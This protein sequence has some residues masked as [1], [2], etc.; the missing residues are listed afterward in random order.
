M[1]QVDLNAIS[2]LQ[3]NKSGR[4][5]CS[6]P[7]TI[8]STKT[9]VAQPKSDQVEVSSLGRE[10][11][12]LV[13]KAKGLSDI[14]QERVEQLRQMVQSGQYFVSSQTIADAILRDENQ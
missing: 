9:T 1:K 3:T 7:S 14:R 5:D 2:S 11:G 10:I 8:N 4:A 6:R 13:D 12:E